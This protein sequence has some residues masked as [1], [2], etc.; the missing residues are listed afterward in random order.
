MVMHM[1]AGGEGGFHR[2]DS[3]I[4]LFGFEILTV[5]HYRAR[6]D[7][8]FVSSHQRGLYPY[9]SLLFH[10]LAIAVVEIVTPYCLLTLL[11]GCPPRC[12]SCRCASRQ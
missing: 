6:F 9:L 8:M 1:I 12:S 2:I 7:Y 3:K 11:S 5:K 4:I 10:F